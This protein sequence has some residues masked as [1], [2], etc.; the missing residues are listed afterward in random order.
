[1]ITLGNKEYKASR[2]Q[3]YLQALY[4]LYSH[5]IR[6]VMMGDI[7][8]TCERCQAA[9]WNLQ[10]DSQFKANDDMIST[11]D[12]MINSLVQLYLR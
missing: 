2:K 10:A 5:H 8:K 6:H 12:R 3:N 11:S 1:M 9:V 4:Y 7:Y